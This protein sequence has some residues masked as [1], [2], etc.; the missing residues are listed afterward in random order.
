MGGMMGCRRVGYWSEGV[1]CIMSCKEGGRNEGRSMVGKT[2]Q[3]IKIGLS[4]SS[5]SRSCVH[6]ERYRLRGS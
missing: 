1:S 3:A 4:R 5:L 2:D 6:R